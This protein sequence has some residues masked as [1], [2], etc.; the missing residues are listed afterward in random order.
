MSTTPDEIRQLVLSYGIK[1]SPDGPIPSNVLKECIDTFIPIWTELVNISLTQ[2]SM[3]C[4]KGAIL[5]PLIKDLDELM[6]KDSFKNYRPISNLLFVGKLI[7]RVISI[8]LYKHM[9]DNNL[10]SEVQ[11]GYRKGHSTETLLLK[12]VNDLLDN[13]DR[14]MPSIL[15]LLDLSAAFDTVDQSK[16]LSILCNDI[17]VEGV[18]LKWFESFLQGRTQKV[19]IAK[20]YSPETELKYGVPQGSVL[21]PALFKIYIR[22]LHKY[23]KPIRFDIFGFA[24]DH[25]LIKS[26]L[27]VFQVTALD[28]DIQNCFEVISKWMNEFFLCL[29]ASKTKILI[30]T[31]ALRD[32]VVIQGTFI[33]GKCIRFVKSAKNLG[34]ILDSELSF[35]PQI[36]KLVKSCFFVIRRLSK[37]KAYL[38]Y[39]QLRSVVCASIFS[40]LDYCNSLYYGLNSQL[41]AK[42]QSVQNSAV[43][44]LRKKNGLGYLS[45][46]QYIRSC[47]W[48]KV[49]ARI[50]FKLCLIAHKCLHGDAPRSL[51]EILTYNT[52]TRTLKL[53]EYPYNS[54]YGERRFARVAPKLWN[55]L[56]FDIRIESRT[57]V[58]KT[59]L[60][61][62]LFDE[63]ERLI[64]K[65]HE[66]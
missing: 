50:L 17:G 2:G 25:Q 63:S 48:L 7:E 35:E 13:C 45:I 53:N 38:T 43:R 65:L 42:L 52:S 34:V 8:R 30:I 55:L 20:E 26:F 6:D 58:F 4:L 12:V 40:R 24:D 54:C 19:K 18:A 29:N 23:I 59:C 37:I 15:M 66:R 1:C 27:P 5:L 22:S 14:K 64:Q 9:D 33:N 61:T 31:P 46:D 41:H 11:Y 10:H 16:L 47:H 32:E 44:L 57:D 49:K 60:K 21:G 62:Y 36:I 56:P 39:D 3:E 28:N 51:R